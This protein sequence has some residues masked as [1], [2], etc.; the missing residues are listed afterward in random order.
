M[1]GEQGQVDWGHFGPIQ[2][3]RAKRPLM[4][5][6]A[7]SGADLVIV[8]DDNPRSEDP[9]AIRK[10]VLGGCVDAIEIGDRAGAIERGVSL[11]R[12]GDVLLI[13]GKGCSS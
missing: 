8:T 1:P 11:L 9:A 4:G 3:G 10:A 5:K 6:A 7:A 13:L 12:E 2:I